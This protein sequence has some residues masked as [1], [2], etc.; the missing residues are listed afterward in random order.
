MSSEASCPFLGAFSF[1]IF[2]V[3]SSLLIKVD[4]LK[5]EFLISYFDILFLKE[6]KYKMD[7]N[8]PAFKCQAKNVHIPL[9]NTYLLLPHRS[10]IFVLRSRN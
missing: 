7:V 1:D 10:Q 2:K 6:A 3:L 8:D 5:Q 4:L 9:S